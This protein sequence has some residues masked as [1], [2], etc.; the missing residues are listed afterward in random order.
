MSRE[1]RTLSYLLHP[2]LLDELGLVSAL[3]S[4]PEDSASAAE[5]N[6]NWTFKL[7]LSSAA[8]SRDGAIPHR[9]GKSGKHSAALGHQKAKIHLRGDTTCV[10]L[11]V[12]DRGRGMDKKAIERGNGSGTRLGVESWACANE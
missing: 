1:I 4:M 2:P 12:I 11:E 3:K 8:G 9:A 10:G 7:I 5:S 6:W